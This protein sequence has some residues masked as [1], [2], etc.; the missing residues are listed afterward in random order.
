MSFPTP[1]ETLKRS[2]DTEPGLIFTPDLRLPSS[3]GSYSR[4]EEGPNLTGE[5][6]IGGCYIDDTP[7]IEP[8]SRNIHRTFNSQ[9]LVDIALTLVTR[10]SIQSGAFL[11]GRRPKSSRYASTAEV[12]YFSKPREIEFQ[13]LW[14]TFTLNFK[15]EGDARVETSGVL[16]SAPAPQFGI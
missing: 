8:C 5:V 14:A 12:H 11:S 7:T 15:Q 3:S 6:G 16:P 9:T 2:E 10:N 1:T 13:K 4:K